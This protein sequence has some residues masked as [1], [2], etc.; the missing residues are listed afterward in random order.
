MQ[1]A[2]WSPT[3]GKI[4]DVRAGFRMETG[5]SQPSMLPTKQATCMT[6]GSGG[7]QQTQTDWPESEEE[8]WESH[9]SGCSS[10]KQSVG[11]GGPRGEQ[12]LA[13]LQSQLGHTQ[14]SVPDTEV[15]AKVNTATANDNDEVDM[16]ALW[17]GTNDCSI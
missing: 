4:P 12:S 17:G 6:F 11:A 16:D 10:R 9:K 14:A 5:I 15:A 1:T 3:A 8:E 2:E 7:P 13:A